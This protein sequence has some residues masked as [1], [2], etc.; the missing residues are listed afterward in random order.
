MIGAIGRGALKAAKF[1]VGTRGG[2]IMASSLVSGTYAA[3]TGTE[4]YAADRF[5]AG[6]I[7]GGY[8]GGMLQSRAFWKGAGNLAKRL[9]GAAWGAAKA[10][11]GMAR[12]AFRMATNKNTYIAAGAIGAVGGGG[13][14]YSE[15]SR[16]R[17]VSRFQNSTMGL[18]QGMHS[19]RHR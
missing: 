14:M 13:Y 12:G 4:G 3:A 17:R 2:R 6:A 11:P 9:P 10:T 15:M 19:R 18:V 5:I 16:Q 8:A 7:I 1:G